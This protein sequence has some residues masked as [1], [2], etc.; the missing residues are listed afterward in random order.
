[1]E[2]PRGLEP[3]PTAW[4]AVVLPLYY[5]RISDQKFITRWRKRHKLGTEARLSARP[6][7]AFPSADLHHTRCLHYRRPLLPLRKARGLGAVGIHARKFVAIAVVHGHL[8]MAMLS[9]LIGPECRALLLFLFQAA[10][11]SAGWQNISGSSGIRKYNL[12]D[13]LLL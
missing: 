2:R 11:H 5:G 10:F 8:I 7:R 6:L 4:Q 3:P 13:L 1:M 9:P 12:A